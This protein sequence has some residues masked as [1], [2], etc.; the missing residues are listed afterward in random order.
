VPFAR[1]G[2]LVLLKLVLPKLLMFLRHGE[3][4][5]LNL[6]CGACGWLVRIVMFVIDGEL[7]KKIVMAVLFVA[8]G[9]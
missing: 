2:L 4:G 9:P 1:L 8:Y 3:V 6:F 7:G 5:T